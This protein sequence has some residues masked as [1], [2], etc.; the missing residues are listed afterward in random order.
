MRAELLMVI[1]LAPGQLKQ[2]LERCATYLKLDESDA[3]RVSS[4][5]LDPKVER[6][7]FEFY[8]DL[9]HRGPHATD[10]RAGGAHGARRRHALAG[11]HR[12]RT[13]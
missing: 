11:T 4:V 3:A 2:E 5:L 13:E 12:A 6:Y 8:G 9:L 1:E 10:W 7:N